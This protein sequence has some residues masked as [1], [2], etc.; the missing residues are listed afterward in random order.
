MAWSMGSEFG[1]DD[2]FRTTICTRFSTIM[3]MSMVITIILHL[4]LVHLEKISYFQLFISCAGSGR[5]VVAIVS[6]TR[7]VR[8]DN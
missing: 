5:G 3:L 7:P 8:S 6:V 4:N 2:P 1:P